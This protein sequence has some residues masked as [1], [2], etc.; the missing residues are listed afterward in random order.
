[1]LDSRGRSDC[2]LRVAQSARCRISSTQEANLAT[3]LSI[4][5]QHHLSLGHDDEAYS[6]MVFNPDHARRKDCLRQ[7]ISEL[8]SKGRS[9][10]LATFPYVDLLEEVERILETRARALDPHQPLEKTTAYDFLYA[11]H[12]RRNNFRKAATIMFEQVKFI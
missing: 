10:K 3:L 5:F 2:I 12:I 11:F 9:R 7:L 4:E 1:M 8:L 6:A